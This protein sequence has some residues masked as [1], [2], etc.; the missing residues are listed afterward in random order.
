[1]NLPR[2]QQTGLGRG[3]P[4]ALSRTQDV[5]RWIACGLAAVLGTCG[6]ALS[7]SHAGTSIPPG[8]PL[9]CS[10]ASELS[11]ASDQTT[12]S[13]AD[14]T[15]ATSQTDGYV[16]VGWPEGGGEAIYRLDIVE[17]LVLHVTLTSIHDLDLFLLTACHSDSCLL[18]S[19]RE[20]LGAISTGSY[21]LVV[22][23]NQSG[24][25]PFQLEL[26][27][28]PAGV[29]QIACD[30]TKPLACVEGGASITGSVYLQ[31]A[32]VTY[33]DCSPVLVTGT[34]R[35]H[36]LLLPEGGSLRA[37]L[38]MAAA[39]GVLWLFDGCGDEANCVAFAD[40]TATGGQEE[41]NLTNTTG[42]DVTYYLVVD[43]FRPTTSEEEGEFDLTVS[44]NGAAAPGHI[45][46]E[47]AEVALEVVCEGTTLDLEGNLFGLPNRL[48]TAPCGAFVSSGGEQWYGLILPDD[49]TVTITLDGMKFDGALWLFDGCGPDASCV[50]FADDR[51]EWDNPLGHVEVVVATKQAGGGHTYYLAVD[52]VRDTDE[53]YEAFWDYNLTIECGAKSDLSQPEPAGLRRL[54]R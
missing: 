21:F 3:A 50:A 24:R 10:G 53:E 16:C 4:A 11:I 42:S 22:D 6:V 8:V 46:P 2:R 48:M 15:A 40:R 32:F 36:S 39:D 19:N 43:T 49:A 18:A 31:G 38:R 9:D 37:V 1:M 35:W 52:T 23:S 27:G 41:L 26:S 45:P 25:Q 34:E 13:L 51:Y 17:N 44:C 29:P 33:A 28:S 30:L 14:T 54:W 5:P 47:V 20:I 7:S 12:I